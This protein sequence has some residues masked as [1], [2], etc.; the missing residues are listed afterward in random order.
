[1]GASVSVHRICGSKD[2]GFPLKYY[3]IS[4]KKL[5]I[6][7]KINK[8]YLKN[9]PSYRSQ[10]CSIFWWFKRSR[11]S[12]KKR[13]NIDQKAINYFENEQILPQKKAYFEFSLS[14]IKAQ[15][16]L[17]FFVESDRNVSNEFLLPKK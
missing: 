12:L 7:L 10:N 4:T 17:F 5:G 1:M 9:T 2:W 13:L 8:Y 14:P 15:G 11:I 6:T 16:V 3:V